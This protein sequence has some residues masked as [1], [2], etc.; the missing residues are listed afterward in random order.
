MICTRR[1]FSTGSSRGNLKTYE[2][3]HPAKT[4]IDAKEKVHR[5]PNTSGASQHIWTIQR[6]RTISTCSICQSI[7]QQFD[8]I[9]QSS[10]KTV[11]L[12]CTRSYTAKKNEQFAFRGSQD[13]HLWKQC[14][15][16]ICKYLPHHLKRKHQ[17]KKCCAVTLSF[18]GYATRILSYDY[19]VQ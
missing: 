17:S 5:I 10:S 3:K 1:Q 12:I 16:G 14:S 18:Q 7:P 6:I 19:P 9:F 4:P 2:R 8:M 11:Q 15:R 13:S